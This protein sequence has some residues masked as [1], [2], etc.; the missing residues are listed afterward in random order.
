[1]KEAYACVRLSQ[2]KPDFASQNGFDRRDALAS[3]RN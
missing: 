1:M 3:R 2:G